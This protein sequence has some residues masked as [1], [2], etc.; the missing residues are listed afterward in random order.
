MTMTDLRAIQSAATITAHDTNVV[1]VGRLFAVNCTVAG[2]VTVRLRDATTHV[3]AV[4][5]GYHAF[6][7]AVIGVNT[8][9]TTATAT[10]SN[11]Y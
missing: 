6:P 7:Y 10:Y 2:N 3:I 1:P 11:L 8:T 5:V 9:G 4:T